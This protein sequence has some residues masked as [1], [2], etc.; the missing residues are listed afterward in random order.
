MDSTQRDAADRRR[1]RSV[2]PHARGWARALF[3]AAR[4]LH[5]A[6]R[7]EDA[8]TEYRTSIRLRPNEAA[9]PVEL[10]R[11][12]IAQQRV[13]EARTELQRA[14]VAEPEFPDALAILAFDAITEG[15]EAAARGWLQRVA[16]QPRVPAEQRN[17]LTDS[18]FSKFGRRFE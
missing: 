4:R 7:I 8:I 14:L 2:R 5:K 17:R 6:G 15:D 11:L 13:P 10:A 16:N 9:T 12:L 1:S 18:F 3:T